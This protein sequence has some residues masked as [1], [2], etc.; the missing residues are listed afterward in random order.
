HF[1][2]LD[3]SSG[4]LVT[5]RP[6][7]PS[8]ATAKRAAT[9]RGMRVRICISAP[10][11]RGIGL[12]LRARFLIIE[13]TVGLDRSGQLQRDVAADAAGL[14]AR[15]EGNVVHGQDDHA[16][17]RSHAADERAELVVAADHAQGDRLLGVELLGRLRAGP[18]QLVAQAG[19]QRGLRDVDDQVRHLGL[20]RQ[21]P[22][23][24]LQ[25]LLRLRELQLER[26]E[27]RG[28]AL[29]GL[30]L[31]AQVGFL[32]FEPLQRVGLVADE[33]P[34]GHAHDQRDDD[35]AECVL[36]L[37]RPGAGVVEVEVADG[38]LLPAHEAVP[39]WAG[40]A[41]ACG[42]V[43]AGA[44]GTPSPS[45]SLGALGLASRTVS[46]KVNGKPGS[47]ALASMTD[48]SGRVIQPE[49]SRLRMYV[50]IRPYDWPRPSRVSLSPS[51]LTPVRMTPSGIV[52]TSESNR[53]T[54]CERLA[55]SCSMTSL[56]A[57]SLAF[58]WSRAS[59]SLILA[60]T[61]VIWSRRNAL[62]SSWPSIC[63]L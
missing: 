31:G 48:S 4:P 11:L 26:L 37:A 8:T 33:E 52:R 19:G 27:V 53:W 14:V 25:L 42:E 22:Q 20:A 10:S 49:L 46:V 38:H 1:S 2:R 63:A 32:A 44:S 57:S 18:E 7:A 34:P 24:L 15:L 55:C 47:P 17:Q 35:R 13:V 59:I 45:V 41:D 39:P 9:M 61:W 43:P 29:L 30:E 5:L 36:V 50:E 56:R 60:S 54:I 21:L 6:Q 51:C 58:F 62:R 28:A 12:F 16:R 40:A 23:H 3:G